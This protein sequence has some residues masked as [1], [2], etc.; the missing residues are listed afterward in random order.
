[1]KKKYLCII[2]ARA[3]SKG[4]KDKN[5]VKIKNKLLIQYSIDTAKKLQKYCDIV[6]SSDSK[7]IKKICSINKIEFNGFRPKYLSGDN[8]ETYRVIRYELSK[9]EK[10]KDKIYKGVLLLQPTC[11]IRNEKKIIKAFKILNNSKFDS[12]VSVSSVG[13]MHPERM[14]KFK[15]KYLVNYLGGK[16]ENML[17]RQKLPNV[18]IR[19]GSIYLTTRDSL[20]RNKSLVGKR[21]YG[22]VIDGLESINI[23][24][25]DDLDLLKLKL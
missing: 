12:L 21:C 15:K 6:I 19:S 3:G 16:K 25:K 9:A 14:K 5:F 11:P 1:M 17:P 23:D 8:V 7:K 2:P 4:I 13:P 18:Y 20:I 10:L 22:L 24:T